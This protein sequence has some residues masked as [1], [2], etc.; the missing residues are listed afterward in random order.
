MAKKRGGVSKSQAIRDYCGANPKA[1]PKEVADALASQG[2]VVTPQFV[3][4]IRSNAKRK[5]SVRRPGRPAKSASAKR[6][7]RPAR[8]AGKRRSSGGGS[9]SEVSIDS[10]VKAKKIVKEMGSVEDAKKA[11]D[12]LSKLMD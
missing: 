11:L 9:S 1:K 6:P 4:T 8:A 12:A 3:S 5:K 7:G 2:V 10:L